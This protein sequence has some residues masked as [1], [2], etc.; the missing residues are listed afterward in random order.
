HEP[1]PAELDRAVALA[2]FDEVVALRQDQGGLEALAGYLG[3]RLSGGEKQR[4]AL[5]RLILRDPE[6][7]ICDEYTANVDVRTARLIHDAVRTHFAGRTRVII[8][9]ELASA[10]G[11]DH[12]L[13]VDHGRLVQEGTPDRLREQPGL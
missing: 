11:A 9:H 13:V 4:L 1:T 7:V 6:V 12:I 3:S 8:S 10:R 2:Q 5:A